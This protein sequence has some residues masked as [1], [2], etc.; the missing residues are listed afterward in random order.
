MS[1]EFFFVTRAPALQRPLESCALGADFERD[2]IPQAWAGPSQPCSPFFRIVVGEFWAGHE[3]TADP[4]HPATPDHWVSMVLRYRLAQEP[5]GKSRFGGLGIFAAAEFLRSPPRGP[6]LGDLASQ[7]GDG[8]PSARRLDE[9][10]AGLF[11]PRTRATGGVTGIW[12]AQDSGPL[13][14]RSRPGSRVGGEPRRP[15][16]GGIQVSSGPAPRPGPAAFRYSDSVRRLQ[17]AKRCLMPFVLIPGCGY[18]EGG[19][20]AKICARR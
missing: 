17:E 15:E 6:G 19:H 5:G 3:L 2:R 4:D 9:T 8:G 13:S 12:P 14:P 1:E 7:G 11:R 18:E 16:S 10:F 20:Q